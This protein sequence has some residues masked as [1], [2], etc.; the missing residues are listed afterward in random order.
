MRLTGNAGR[1]RARRTI[2]ARWPA[3]VHSERRQAVR[4]SPC[5]RCWVSRRPRSRL[6]RQ[7]LGRPR[8][9]STGK[10]GCTCS[11]CLVRRQPSP[12]I[13]GEPT[14]PS[15]NVASA[16]DRW[17]SNRPASGSF[18]RWP[19][20][21]S[22]ACWSYPRYH[23][24]GW[25]NVPAI[26]TLATDAVVV[27]AFWIVFLVFRVNTFTAA[28]VGVA[29]GQMVISQGP[30]RFVRHPMYAGALL[31][32]LA[33][34]IALESW[35]GLIAVCTDAG[36]HRL[37]LASG[38]GIVGPSTVWVRGLSRAGA[39]PPLAAR[40]VRVPG[41]ACLEWSA[42]NHRKTYRGRQL[43]RT[44]DVNCVGQFGRCVHHKL[45]RERLLEEVA[46]VRSVLVHEYADVIVHATDGILQSASPRQVGLA[47]GSGSTCKGHK[48]PA[49][50]DRREPPGIGDSARTPPGSRENDPT[51]RVPAHATEFKNGG[52]RIR[53]H[54]VNC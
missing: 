6:P 25:S 13:C 54:S 18:N 1:L 2:Q 10:G 31:M 11:P 19:L 14:H 17:L 39:L 35:W 43:G 51:E 30:Y 7:Y 47:F 49:L 22:S 29:T 45:R 5:V 26:V 32:L 37:A 44:I 52:A 34:P 4:V 3:H 40:L 12:C 16:V 33:I 42:A 8:P 23:R 48:E 50:L 27:L 38:G 46:R 9:L 15:L 53:Q 36:V 20:W 24:F 28:T 41:R 21:P